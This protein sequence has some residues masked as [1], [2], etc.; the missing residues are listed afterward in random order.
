MNGR[1]SRTALISL[2]TL[3]AQ[4]CVDKKLQTIWK[5]QQHFIKKIT[6][7]YKITW[8]SIRINCFQDSSY[9][10]PRVTEDG[11]SV[12]HVVWCVWT[13]Y[14]SCSAL[15]PSLSLSLPG[16]S[17]ILVLSATASSSFPFTWLVLSDFGSS[18][19][20][21]C[22]IG[23]SS[24]GFSEPAGVDSAEAWCGG[25]ARLCFCWLI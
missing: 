12:G 24:C 19:D 6:D 23:V 11:T 5:K 20:G 2:N 4:S 7:C 17:G 21:S 9:V 1:D 15:L 18:S 3:T 22:S 16:C 8:K 25:G 13:P 10:V 14:C